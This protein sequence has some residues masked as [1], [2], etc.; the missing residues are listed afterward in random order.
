MTRNLILIMVLCLA[1]C[2]TQRFEIRPE[3]KTMPMYDFTQSFWLGGIFQYDEID[4]VRVC[5]GANNIQRIE[6]QMTS[7]NVVLAILTL[8]IYTPRQIRVYCTR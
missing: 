3:I 6:T 2:A 1:G 7:D 4:A 8:G 5:R